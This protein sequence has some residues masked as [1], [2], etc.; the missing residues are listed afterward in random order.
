[1]LRVLRRKSQSA[2]FSNRFTP[3]DERVFSTIASQLGSA[4]ENARGFERLLRSERMAAW[5]E[6]SAKS[7]H[8]IGNRSFALKGDL[9][10]LGHVLESLPA[11]A[12]R[13]ELH[14]LVRSMNRGVERLE[15]ILREFRDFVVATQLTRTECDVNVVLREVIAE[16]FPKRSPVRLE[17]SL[18]EGL[19]PVRCDAPKLKR[20]F[21]ELIENALSFQPDGGLLEIGSRLLTTEEQV[22]YRLAPSR[23]YVQISFTDSGPGVPEEIKERI[24]QP[25][26]TS[27]VKGMGLGLSIVKG[28]IEA[29]EG[30]LREVGE[31]GRGARF[32]IFLPVN[33]E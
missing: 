14:A 6:L 16:S 13:D 2:W 7:A 9:N 28:I 10:E 17:L 26:Y 12:Q 30:F 4:V 23:T 32:L 29:H 33:G 25:F 21:S 11:G 3:T 24:F 19:P 27:R 18:S 31:A 1:V 15:E 22:A 8:M 20:A 5:G